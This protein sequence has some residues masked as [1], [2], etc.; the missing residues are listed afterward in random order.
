MQPDNLGPPLKVVLFDRHSHFGQSDLIGPF[1]L[2]K[3]LS[4]APLFCI[5]LARTIINC[6]VAWLGS[7]Q[8][9]CTVPLGMWT[10]RTFLNGKRP[11]V[12]NLTYQTVHQTVDDTDTVELLEHPSCFQK[13]LRDLGS[14][15]IRVKPILVPG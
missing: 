12:R 9:E 1:H 6:A 14:L 13:I 7:V 4:P 5:V 3:L 10:F 11:C 8:P 15:D 2:T